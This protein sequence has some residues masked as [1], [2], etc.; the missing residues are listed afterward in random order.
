MLIQLNQ[1]LWE[2]WV[3]KSWIK[4]TFLYLNT[5]RNSLVKAKNPTD[6]EVKAGNEVIPAQVFSFM[7]L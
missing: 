5:D 6:N 4:F 1:L 3:L 7:S 2:I